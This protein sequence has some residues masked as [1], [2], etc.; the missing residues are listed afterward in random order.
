MV[1]DTRER[2]YSFVKDRILAG[3]PPTVREVQQA[4]GFKS[5]ATAREHL[6]R[7]VS[8]GRLVRESGLSRGFRL[9][10][11]ASAGGHA[12]LIPVL[13]RVQAG[14]WN[15]AVE[16]I[17]GYVW[18]PD[19][20][21]GRTRR[22]KAPDERL[23]ALR[24][25]GESMVGKGILP[26]DLVIVRRQPD[27]E[28][29]Q[30]VVALVDDEATVKTLRRRGRRIELHPANPAFDVLRPDPGQLAILGRVVEVRRELDE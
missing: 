5:T 20:Y 4:L 30:I 26:D 11:P 24:V 15:L 18:V 13:G 17:E 27:A 3:V 29:G 14:E 7:L 9:P 28:S 22:T 8:D 25:R 12:L 16:D 23:F 21:A 19:R 10:A 1:S 2:I 6:D